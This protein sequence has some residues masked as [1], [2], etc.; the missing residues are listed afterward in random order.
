MSITLTR[1]LVALDMPSVSVQDSQEGPHLSGSVSLFLNCSLLLC[2]YIHIYII[3]IVFCIHNVL[4][5]LKKL[6]LS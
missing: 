1:F 4:Q 2:P 6:I 5:R 3:F